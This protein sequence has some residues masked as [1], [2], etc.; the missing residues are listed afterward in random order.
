MTTTCRSSRSCPRKCSARAVLPSPERPLMKT[1]CGSPRRCRV[2]IGF[3]ECRQVRIPT[4]Q[5]MAAGTRCSGRVRLQAGGNL[6][7]RS[8][9]HPAVRAGRGPAAACTARPGPSGIAALSGNGGGSTGLFRLKDLPE[10]TVER[11]TARECLVEHHPDGV[12][13]SRGVTLAARPLARGPCRPGSPQSR[14]RFGRRSAR[15]SSRTRPKSRR[16]TWPSCVTITF[17]GFKSR[18]MMWLRCR[19]ITPM[20]SCERAERSRRIVEPRRRGGHSPGN[21]LPRPVPW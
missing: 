6:P 11:P 3:L 9:G 14:R 8:R 13:I 16:M 18:W 5:A 21:R 12:P 2:P 7:W 1:V 19:A 15:S 17:E 20:A 10:R 4:H